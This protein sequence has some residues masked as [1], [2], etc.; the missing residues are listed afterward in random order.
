MIFFRVNCL[1]SPGARDRLSEGVSW[2]KKLIALVL[3]RIFRLDSEFGELNW[4]KGLVGCWR[5][6]FVPW[7]KYLLLSCTTIW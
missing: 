1:F 2:W 5:F 7:Q 6:T 3:Y 4:V